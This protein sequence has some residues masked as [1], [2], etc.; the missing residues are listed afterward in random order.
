MSASTLAWWSV[1]DIAAL[2]A[3]LASVTVRVVAADGAE[4]AA[5]E[6]A[7]EE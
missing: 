3:G 7:D 5:K 6:G 2:I 4:G 1:A